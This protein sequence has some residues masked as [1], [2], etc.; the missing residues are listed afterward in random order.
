MLPLLHLLIPFVSTHARLLLSASSATVT[1]AHMPSVFP[2]IPHTQELTEIEKRLHTLS[3]VEQP[4]LKKQKTSIDTKMQKLLNEMATYK[5][6]VCAR[7]E[8]GSAKSYHR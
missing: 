6:Y 3:K 2:E 1:Y 8:I 4:R 7:S 5:G